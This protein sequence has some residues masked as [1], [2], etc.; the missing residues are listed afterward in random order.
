MAERHVSHT[1]CGGSKVSKPVF[2][3]SGKRYCKVKV[4]WLFYKFRLVFA[5]V[6]L[7]VDTL[8]ASV[9]QRLDSPIHWINLYPED[10]TN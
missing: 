6:P 4:I 9:V 5:A 1:K 2:R 7:F 8:Q 3:N 10:T